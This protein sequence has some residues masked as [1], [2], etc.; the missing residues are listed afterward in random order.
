MLLLDSLGRHHTCSSVSDS[1]QDRMRGQYSC[2]SFSRENFK[3]K[4]ATVASGVFIVIE[5]PGDGVY[6][7]NEFKS[8]RLSSLQRS[9][10][11][12]FQI[13][14]TMLRCQNR[15]HVDLGQFADGSTCAD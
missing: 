12:R 4:V 3:N 7:T 10:R 13:L 8:L 14:R 5:S 11:G 6:L 15:I 2:I 1:T 9:M